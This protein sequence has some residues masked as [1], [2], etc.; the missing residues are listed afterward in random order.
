MYACEWVKIDQDML[1]KERII[2]TPPGK[3]YFTLPSPYIL[4]CH[5]LSSLFLFLSL[6]LSL[7]LSPPLVQSFSLPTCSLKD[8]IKILDT[9]TTSSF[10]LWN[11]YTGKPTVQVD[12][13]LKSKQPDVTI[14]IWNEVGWYFPEHR[15]RSRTPCVV[16]SADDLLHWRSLQ[17]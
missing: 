14:V 7:S 4:Y 3:T 17:T 13:Q 11:I 15:F 16:P 12:H 2:S 1:K 5:Y 9:W 8:L 6:S 10:W